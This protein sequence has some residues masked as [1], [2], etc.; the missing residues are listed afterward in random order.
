MQPLAQKAPAK[1][2]SSRVTCP[3]FE[4]SLRGILGRFS[5]SVAEE[6]EALNVPGRSLRDAVP[7]IPAL[8]FALCL[9]TYPESEAR[10]KYKAG[11]GNGTRTR[12]TQLGRLAL[13]HLSYSRPER[14]IA[15]SFRGSSTPRFG[16]PTHIE[17]KAKIPVYILWNPSLKRPHIGDNP[18]PFLEFPKEFLF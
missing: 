5:F 8:G 18:G 6:I 13:Y 16:L 17:E 7:G 3:L 12:G 1:K 11:A 10:R 4:R 2:K 14:I 15:Q 9:Q